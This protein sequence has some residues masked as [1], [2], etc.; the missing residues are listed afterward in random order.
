MTGVAPQA[1]QLAAR[2]LQLWTDPEL[3]KRE[4]ERM[5]HSNAEWDFMGRSFLV[6]SLAEMSLREPASQAANLPVI[7]Q[8]IA[9]TVRLERTNG[10]YV[11]LMPYAKARPYVAQPARSLFLDGEIALMLAARRM[12]AER[13]DYR[14]ALTERVSFMLE[15]LRRSKALAAESYPDE[16]WLFDHAV[17]LAAIKLADHLDGTDHTAFF[18]E[19]PSRWVSPSR[20]CCSP[21]FP[22]P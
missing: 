7:D 6:W 19:W 21:C 13:P 20:T 10:I 22:P 4:L 8:I 3:K 12:V 11:F 16:C 15:R 9:E 5:R 1:Q 2:H 14:D 17:A 18:R